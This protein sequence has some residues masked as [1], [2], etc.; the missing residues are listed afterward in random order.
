LG[1]LI[2][3]ADNSYFF[4]GYSN[5][6]QTENNYGTGINL[7][8]SVSTG[9]P[10]WGNI[11]FHSSVYEVFS[12]FRNKNADS[13]DILFLY[14]DLSYSYPLGEHWSIGLSASA[15]WNT[16]IVSIFKNTEKGTYTAELF[17]GRT[18]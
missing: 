18:W 1:G 7:K 4:N 11:T 17:I 8:F 10:K 12:V 16:V 9:H 5:L 2:F 6:R 15:F 3:N 14:F 13:R